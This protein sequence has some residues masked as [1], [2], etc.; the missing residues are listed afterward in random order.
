MRKLGGSGGALRGRVLLWAVMAMAAATVGDAAESR[1]LLGFE[2][3][4][5]VNSVEIRSGA[6][7]L[8][9][10][11]ATQ[12]KQC[13]K[14][15]A[16]D[17]LTF[18][19]LPRDWS[20]YDA[21][22]VDIYCELGEPASLYV[23]IGDEEWSAK[24]SYW[25]RY[26]ADYSLRPGANTI[27]IPLGGL[28]RGEAGSRYNDLKTNIDAAKITRLDLGFTPTGGGTGSIYVDNLRLTRWS[29]PA[30]VR[31]FDFGP[32]GQSVAPGF[33]A[34]SPEDEYTD[35]RGWGWQALHPTGGQAG[36]RPGRA[37]DVTFPSRLLQDS[38]DFGEATFEVKLPKGQYRVLVF[39]EDLGYWSGEQAQ[40]DLREVYGGDWR[41]AE[42]HG[43]WGRFDHIYQFQD[44]E[45]LPGADV[46]DV[47]M[48]YLFRPVTAEVSV[49][50]GLFEL[51][52]KADGPNARRVAGVV[53]Y[54]KGDAAA[55]KWAVGVLFQQRDEF[56][57]RAVELSLPKTENPAP[58]T[59]AD[60]RRGYLLFIPRIEENVYFSAMPREDELRSSME[61]FAS[62]G[63]RRSLT[64]AVRPLKDLGT[65]KLEVSDLRGE[66]GVIPASQITVSVVRHLPTRSLGSLMY[67]VTPRYLVEASEVELPK[68]LTRQIWLTVRVPKEAAAGEYQGKLTIRLASQAV[69]VPIRLR[70]LPFSLEEADFL[71]GFWGI[72]PDVPVQGE[73]Y[74][75]V[76][77]GVFA[78][79][80]ER[81]LTSFTGGPGIEFK[82]LDESGEPVMDFAA[83]D[84]FVAEARA[85]GFGREFNNYGGFV[86]RGLYDI[87]DYT[88]GETG[89]ALE[90]KYNLPYEE[91]ARRVWAAVEKHSQEQNWLPF[92]YTMCDETRVA[93]KAQEQL[94]LMEVFN[95]VSPW[96]RTAGGYSVS[97]EPTADPLE[98]A[99]QGFFRTLD[100]S[101][102][103]NH[104]ELLMEK[105]RELGKDVYIY[106]QGRTRYSFGLYQ[107]SERAK[108]V[109]GRYEWISFIRHGYEYFDLD[110]R[111]PD[112][113][114]VFFS[115]EGLRP[116]L[117][118]EQCGEGMN[119]FRY[120]QTLERWAQVG[121][122]S[123]AEEARKLA[124]EARA[125][126]RETAAGIELGQRGQPARVNLDEM[127][128][129]AADR[130][131]GLM[132]AL[133]K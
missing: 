107:W 5:E 53:L 98:L 105:A 76:Q 36:A 104:D 95:R 9:T 118:L 47:Y 81:G 24:S 103:N 89:A 122:Q 132:S 48:S 13:L 88:K 128:A 78:M 35:Q 69:E 113:S 25:N 97:W 29:R 117:M 68:D 59:P 45:P 96:L 84:K 131:A 49:G 119:D 120:L 44:T 111:E 86:V 6:G 39:F 114:M 27:S 66:A 100:V 80:R 4:A 62:R 109:K 73:E 112:P 2:T 91:I 67:R 50:D 22:E 121:E 94:D 82:G 92:S 61:A 41:V 57:A 56:R 83:A 70:V 55:E 71:C 11:H 77:R 60:R 79:F 37:W 34:V 127:R 106:N 108:G 85:A 102:V 26:D 16:E 1:L 32:A 101:I 74:D 23:L 20:G 3:Q 123:D 43:K 12:G 54:P 87:Y 72:E 33:T 63:E 125:F 21:L 18:L 124:A 58:V 7:A 126:L 38:I 30:S 99:L 40:Y 15:S 31:A 75:A 64:A 65:G 93:E 10:Q 90:Q 129:Q 14:V 116:S 28:Y 19:R 52:V 51:R 42:G 133:G 110:G 130:I 115:S 46:W 17:Y 8:S